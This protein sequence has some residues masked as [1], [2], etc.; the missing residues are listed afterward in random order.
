MLI[1]KVKLIFFQRHLHLLSWQKKQ[2]KRKKH[3]HGRLKKFKTT[4]L[5]NTIGVL[6]LNN[7]VPGNV[8]LD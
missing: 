7:V 8:Q 4:L 1:E 6:R 3:G 2:L 5:N